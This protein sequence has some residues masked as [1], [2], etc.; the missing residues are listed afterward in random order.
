MLFENFEATT[1]KTTPQTGPVKTS[2]VHCLVLEFRGVG[3]RV[4]VRGAWGRSLPWLSDAGLLAVVH[5]RE[6]FHLRQDLGRF[7]PQMVL[8]NAD[9]GC[10]WVANVSVAWQVVRYVHDPK[11]A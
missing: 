5:P 11:A 2:L 10:G 4:V 7:R 3:V 6:A 8:A 9:S 1:S